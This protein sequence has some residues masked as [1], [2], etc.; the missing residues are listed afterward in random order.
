MG[1]FDEARAQLDGQKALKLH[2]AG[3]KASNE[4]KPAEAAE[5]YDQAI[6]LYERA[7]HGGVYKPALGQSYAVLLMRLGS[8][9]EARKVMENIARM[10]GLTDEDWFGLR[11]NYSLY[12]WKMGRLDEALSTIGRAEAY[13]KNSSIYTTK[14]MFLVDK[15]AQTG[16]FETAEAFNREALDYDDED[17]GVL[18]NVAALCEAR[19][20]RCRESGDAA[21]AADYRRQAVAYYEK[22]HQFKPRQITTI[23]ALA[24]LRHE[25]GDDAGARELLSGT[26]NLFFSAL[27]PVT[28]TMMDD[29]KREI[30]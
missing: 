11:L 3:N 16:D 1:F 8:F 25:D 14:G 29:L 27:C 15:A 20:D 19:M 28:K 22:A 18:D 9:D 6:R 7:L 17:G 26:D 2:I 30:G 4:G 12:H 5:K 21:A 10:R 24:K 13:K 23:Y